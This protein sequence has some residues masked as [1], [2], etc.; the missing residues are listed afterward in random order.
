MVPYD[1]RHAEPP[2]LRR[3]RPGPIIDPLAPRIL[4]MNRDTLLRHKLLNA[5]QTLLLIVG[6]ALVLALSA[7]LLFGPGVTL[8]VFGWVALLMWLAPR[9][10][11]AVI[12]RLYGARPLDPV[13]APGLSAMAEELARR[14]GLPRVPKLYYVPSA[15][16]NA[17]AV[18][19]REQAAI[20]VT[21]GLMRHLTPRE[22]RGVLAHEISHVR[23]NDMWVM[24]LSDTVSRLTQMLSWFGQF[25][26]LFNLPLLMVS[27]VAISWTGLLLLVFAPQISALLQLALSRTREFDADLEAA[28]LTGDPEGL[29]MAL[30]KLEQ[31]QGGW[32]ERVLAPGRGNP[33]PSLL[34]THPPTD[35]RVRRLLELRQGG[36]RPE[37]VAPLRDGF[38]T[39]Q[40]MVT[41]A[42]RR[43]LSGLWY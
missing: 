32:L 3:R 1:D 27:G 15:L 4:D 20:A 11:P 10:S 13:S 29:A 39:R 24:G 2:A 36:T 9:L 17:F 25:L 41:R 21:D 40:P 18:G 5:A 19:Q 22:L 38:V 31:V 35:E 16:L 7:R 6:M 34:R 33:E 30:Q 12:L 26:I 43:H 28:R 8:W 42:P 14:A 23:N 37:A